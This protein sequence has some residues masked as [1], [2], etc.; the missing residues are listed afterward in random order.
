MHVQCLRQRSVVAIQ[1]ALILLIVS[2]FALGAAVWHGTVEL[3]LMDVQYQTVRIMAYTMRYSSCPLYTPCE[4]PS[5]THCSLQTSRAYYEV[6]AIYELP[7]VR[8]PHRRTDRRL[9]ALPLHH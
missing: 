7:T 2:V 3:P 6:W 4:C 8:Q 9:F 5:Y 1:L